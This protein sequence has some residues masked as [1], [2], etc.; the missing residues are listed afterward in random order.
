M[1]SSTNVVIYTTTVTI[2]TGSNVIAL[3]YNLA[4]GTNYRLGLSSTSGTGLYRTT[5]GVAYP[6]NVA[7]C[8]NMTSS[9]AGNGAYYYFYNW[10]I[11]RPECASARIPVVASMNPLPVLSMNTP[12]DPICTD[13]VINLQGTPAGG[14]YMGTNV[15][16]PLFNANASGPGTYTVSYM[17]T[18][19]NTCSNTL[20]A[21]LVV[22]E[23]TGITH[24]GSLN[25]SVLIYPNPAKDNLV[26]SN[27][28]GSGKMNITDA[29]GRLMLARDLTST[30]EKIELNVLA[31]GMYIITIMDGSGKTIKTMKLIKE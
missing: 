23:C 16:G 29:S 25:S 3:N 30:E 22:T 21:T 31:K 24:A 13:D 12:V 2:T 15:S 18:D 28:T 11:S 17:F 19:A 5:T 8:V 9:S 10:Q 7:G 4:P 26:V 1:R 6:Y 20:D 14:S 27:T